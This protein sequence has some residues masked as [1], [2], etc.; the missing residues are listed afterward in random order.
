MSPRTHLTR[1]H[2]IRTAAPRLRQAAVTLERLK[3]LDA[4]PVIYQLLALLIHLSDALP[5]VST[6]RI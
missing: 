2:L 4:E 1:P 6:L 3:S 5:L